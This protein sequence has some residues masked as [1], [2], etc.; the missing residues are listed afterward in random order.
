[1][2]NNDKVR[3]VYIAGVGRSGSTLLGRVLSQS[4]DATFVGEARALPGQISSKCGCGKKVRE[5]RFWSGVLDKVDVDAVR[6][7]RNTFRVRDLVFR[8]PEVNIPLRQLTEYYRAIQRESGAR[9][10]VD[11]SKFP[12]YLFCLSESPGIDVRVL[13]LVRDPRAIAYS[14]WK[15]PIHEGKQNTPVTKRSY[16][17]LRFENPIRSS[18][19]WLIWNHIIKSKWMNNK[20]YHLLKYE[21]FC[22][23]PKKYSN[24]AMSMLGANNM[25]EWVSNN[26]IRLPV[27]H[28]IRGN[29]N[30]FEEGVTEIEER[31][32]WQSGLS[33]VEKLIVVGLTAPLLRE[34]GY[35]FTST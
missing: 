20:N 1:M 3:V 26:E 18:V 7:A 30:R 10:I 21:D 24:K 34:Y 35:S 9:V 29:P 6:Q 32:A 12:S 5:C 31:S 2:E 19:I 33:K 22:S 13:H 27:Q 23:N 17:S 4:G 16:E 15:R 8:H 11:S 14:W 28:S 25:S